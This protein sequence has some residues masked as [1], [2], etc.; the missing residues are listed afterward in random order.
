[1]IKD[2]AVVV[3]GVAIIMIVYR[4]YGERSFPLLALHRSFSWGG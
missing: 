3:R 2:G 1:M 4:L